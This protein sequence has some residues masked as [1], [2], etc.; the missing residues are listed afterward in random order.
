MWG[1][2]ASQQLFN[3]PFDC[4]VLSEQAPLCRQSKNT[5]LECTKSHVQFNT[6]QWVRAQNQ[7]YTSTEVRSNERQLDR[8]GRG[9]G[10]ENKHLLPLWRAVKKMCTLENNPQQQETQLFSYLWQ[11]LHSDSTQKVNW[12]HSTEQRKGTESERGSTV[13]QK[14]L[15][16]SA[17]PRSRTVLNITAA[18]AIEKNDRDRAKGR[19]KWWKADRCTKIGHE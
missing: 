17:T 16:F 1:E 3:H 10:L 13:V 7:R 8:A 6:E 2:N 14:S 12:G 4:F 11:W 15:S 9:G 19:I 18:P 5:R